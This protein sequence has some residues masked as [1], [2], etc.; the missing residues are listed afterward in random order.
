M[1]EPDQSIEIPLGDFCAIFKKETWT[2]N[3]IIKNAQYKGAFYFRH[4][5]NS[6]K[7]KPWFSKL[8]TER[9]FVTL[10]N[11]IKANHLN[12]NESLTRKG[13]IEHAR[14]DCGCECESLQHLIWRCNKY[15]EER[16]KMDT[17]LRVANVTE[18]FIFL[19]KK[20]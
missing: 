7:K 2:Q 6:N 3:S 1:E 19:I 15:D 17:E 8:N 11:R 12:L 10:I 4:F 13:Y 20:N 16:I 14:C 9:Y 5:Y 18:N